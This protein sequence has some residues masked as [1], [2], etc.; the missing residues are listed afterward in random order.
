MTW[1][2]T[3]TV[4]RWRNHFSQLMNGHGVDV[5]Q[6]EIPTAEPLLPEPIAFEFETAIDKLKRHKSPGTV[7]IPAALI[8]AGGRT[9]FPGIHEVINSIWKKKEL[10]EEWKEFNIVPIYKKG[11]KTDCSNYTGMSLSSP[12][13]KM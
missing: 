5:R 1:S 4:A 11:D 6:T 8:K 9:I 2:Q 13:L 12:T 3:P 10:P 7:Q